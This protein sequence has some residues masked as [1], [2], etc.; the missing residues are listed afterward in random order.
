M[1][2]S[3]NILKN[4]NIYEAFSEI[5]RSIIIVEINKYINYEM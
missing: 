5:A 2:K 4:I 3:T 1:L